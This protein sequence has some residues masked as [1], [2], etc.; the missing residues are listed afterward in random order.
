MILIP[1]SDT[2]QIR[3][4]PQ[5]ELERN[6]L[7][8][9]EKSSVV[10]RYDSP[11]ALKFELNLRSRIVESARALH[12]SGVKFAT[13]DD[14]RC[15]EQFW[16]R[17]AN[18]GFRLKN[19][20][21]PSQGIN[22]IFENGNLYAFECS[23]AMVI[24]LYKAVL[25]MIGNSAFNMYFQDLFLWDW[26]YHSNLRLIS[27]HNIQEAYP[28]DVLYFENPDYVPATPEWQGENVI[29]L[30]K[31]LYY[32]HGIGI[33]TAKEMI[34]TLNKKRKPGS[35][36]SAFLSELVLYPDFEYIRRLSS[37]RKGPGSQHENIGNLII[38]RVGINTYIYRNKGVVMKP[39]A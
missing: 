10:Y 22:D 38:A 25:D 33:R 19:G 39:T 35:T 7:Q 37:G 27:K 21:L 1:G 3:R 36:T 4:L 2:E 24:V 34:Y 14:S 13:F 6:I 30:G 9:K 32:G 5:S 11:E 12:D 8:K 28:G 29:M 23:A 16:Y 26:N 20:I 31:G 17:T 18:G 15:N